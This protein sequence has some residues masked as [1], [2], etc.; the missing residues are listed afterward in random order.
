MAGDYGNC[1]SDLLLSIGKGLTVPKGRNPLSV[2]DSVRIDRSIKG[3]GGLIGEIVRISRNP[4]FDFVVRI[5]SVGNE[6]VTA[7]F[8]K[9][10]LF[11]VHP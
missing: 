3:V 6:V 11:R 7:S 1:V 5:G 8:R 2:G 10:E 9:S 4:N